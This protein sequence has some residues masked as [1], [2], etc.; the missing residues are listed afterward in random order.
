MALTHQVVRQDLGGLPDQR[1]RQHWRRH[2]IGFWIVGYAFLVT[3]AF[4]TVP[5]P[6]YVLYQARDHFGSFMVTVIFAAYAVGVVASLFLAGHIS[7]WHGRRRIL[8]IALS[9]NVASGVVFLA[10]PSVPGL[11]VGRV[12]S[13]ISIGMLTAT[14]TAYLSELHATARPGRSRARAEITAT[15]ANIGGLGLGALLAG[16]L[17]QHAPAP[18]QVPYLVS[19]ALM[20][21]GA[22]A[23]AAAPET[24]QRP[25]P[26]PRYRPQRVSVPAPDRSLFY[27]AGLTAATVFALFG[28]FTSLAPGFLA[29]TLHEGSHALAGLTT[30]VVFGAAALAQLAASRTTVHRQL[31]IGLGTLALGLVLVTVAVWLPSLAVLLIGGAL[32][33]GGAGAA[34]KGSISTVISIAPP[35]ARG[36]A[37]AGLFLAAYIGLVVPVLGL[38]LATQLLSTQVAVAGF[39]AVLLAAV[40]V[41]ARSL[42]SLLKDL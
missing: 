38:G 19:E 18:L 37:L 8:A 24:V 35:Q 41:V 15:A 12:V 36:E 17:A 9:V 2:G 39:A 6:L 30:F 31:D 14:A 26:R 34:F 1:A 23:L 3:M 11:I 16:L 5:A 4:S 7:D 13:G 22:I 10:W 25:H 28:L 32:A 20:L 40:A 27:S 29:G 21:I 42:S 33:G